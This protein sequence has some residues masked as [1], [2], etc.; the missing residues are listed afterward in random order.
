MKRQKNKPKGKASKNSKEAMTLVDC[1]YIPTAIAEHFC[2]LREHCATEVEQTLLQHFEKVQREQREDIG[3][4]IVAYDEAGVCHGE[5]SL[6]PTEI[7]KLEK[8]IS[9]ERLDK[10]LEIYFK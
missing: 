8:E 9:A 7:S 3:E 6:S 5:I 10:Y 4:V 1:Y 2:L